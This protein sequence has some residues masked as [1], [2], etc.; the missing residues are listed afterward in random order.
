MAL[1]PVIRINIVARRLTMSVRA[2]RKHHTMSDDFLTS[3]SSSSFSVLYLKLTKQ[4]F[5]AKKN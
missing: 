2:W 4:C 5:L 1:K 3:P